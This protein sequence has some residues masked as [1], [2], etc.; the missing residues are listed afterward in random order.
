MKKTINILFLVGLVFA[1]SSCRSQSTGKISGIEIGKFSAGFAAGWRLHEAGHFVTGKLEG[2]DNLKMGL[3]ET[4]YTYEKYDKSKD[5][6]FLL[7]GFAFDVIGS[8]VVMSNDRLFPKNNNFVLGYLAWTMIEPISYTLRHEFGWE[9]ENGD[10][11]GL[12][13]VGVNPQMM[14]AGLLAHAALTY[15]RLRHN[16]TSPLY[17]EASPRKVMLGAKWEF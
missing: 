10:L 16:P 6:N 3:T 11:R 2:L 8:E 17:V 9:G 13:R 14:E 1:V 15:Y 5:R 4:T 12:E 7:G